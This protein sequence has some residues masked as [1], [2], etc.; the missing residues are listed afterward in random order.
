MIKIIFIL[1]LF[2]SGQIMCEDDYGQTG[3]SQIGTQNPIIDDDAEDTSNT[4]STYIPEYYNSTCYE[5]DSQSNCITKPNCCFVMNFY[6]SFSYQA[7]V[8]ARSS[9]KSK[10]IEF[11]QNFYN[12]NFNQGYTASICHCKNFIYNISAGFSKYSFVLILVIIAA[13]F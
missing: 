6:G 7:C 2:F 9:E 11:C 8:D 13:L 1:V 4:N 12:L 5:T 10:Q 3:N